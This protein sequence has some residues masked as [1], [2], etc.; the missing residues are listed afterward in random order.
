MDL[1][2]LFLLFLIIGQKFLIFL[3]FI[4]HVF[5]KKKLD[6]PLLFVYLL[7]F[8]GDFNLS[9]ISVSAVLFGTELGGNT[10]QVGWI[11]TAYGLSYCFMPAILGVFT[12]RIPRKKSLSIATSFQ[13]LFAVLFIFT[14]YQESFDLFYSLCLIS[15]IGFGISYA[16][17]WPNVEAFISEYTE[18]S[19]KGHERS[20]SNFCVF[21][22]L[23]AALGA[24]AGG[25]L[26][27]IK[28]TIIPFIVFSLFILAFLI[29]RFIVP[30]NS[31]RNQEN[32]QT[33][34]IQG[35]NYIDHKR[36][37]TQQS[38]QKKLLLIILMANLMFAFISRITSTYFPNYA[39]LPRGLSLSGKTIGNIALIFGIARILYFYLGRYFRKNIPSLIV[40]TFSSGLFLIFLY[41]FNEIWIISIIFFIIGFLNGRIYYVALFLLMKFEKEKKG[42]K[43]GFF[44]AMVG[45]GSSISP[46][47]AG[48]LANIS[49]IFPFL[50]Y[51]IFTMAIGLIQYII[52]KKTA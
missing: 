49:L 6:R 5:E 17:Y 13:S 19:E 39:K 27:E 42:T 48:A 14:F 9:F 31:K 2:S 8:I 28:I 20:I 7:G 4:S 3:L 41:F 44:E 47:I 26:S 37:K 35:K 15:L 18:H 24:W 11:G 43:A 25:Y 29:A 51:S 50:V 12:D 52:L 34:E 38:I 45:I 36:T 23:G 21:W 16:F 32:E 1:N 22:G 46:I 10:V 33:Q 40:S 30:A